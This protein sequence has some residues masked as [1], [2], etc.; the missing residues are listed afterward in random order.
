[1]NKL[2]RKTACGFLSAIVGTVLIPTSITAN[3]YQETGKKD[4][5]DWE[6]W[7]QD[8]K[9]TVSMDEAITA[10]SHAAGAVSKT[11][12]SVQ[13][14]NWEVQKLMTSTTAFTSTMM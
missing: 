9:G 7:N 12:F 6:L 4:G 14:R 8:G 5:Y 13:V 3:A 1:M 10:L 11:A 2:F